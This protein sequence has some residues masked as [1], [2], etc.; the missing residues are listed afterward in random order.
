MNKYFLGLVL[1]LLTGI[2]QSQTASYPTVIQ[3]TL[4]STTYSCP[5]GTAAQNKTYVLCQNQPGVITVDFGDGKGYVPLT[6]APGPQ[7]PQGVQGVPG[8]TG[9]IGPTGIA[10]PSGSQGPPGVIQSTI[11]C[12]AASFTETGGIVISGCH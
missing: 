12:T 10:G 2:C 8:P 1:M 3:L 9:A 7:G 6:G 4:A 11:T 5:I